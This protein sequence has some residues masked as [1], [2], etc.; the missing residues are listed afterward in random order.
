[1]NGLKN[2]L[3]D[4]FSYSNNSYLQLILNTAGNWNKKAFVKISLLDV[5]P[6]TLSSIHSDFGKKLVEGF[7]K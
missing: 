5:N 7:V 4:H 1:M 3:D 6:V 2:K